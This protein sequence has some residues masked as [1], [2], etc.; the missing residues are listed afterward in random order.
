MKLLLAEDEFAMAD[1]VE[2]I[3]TY[4]NYIIDS[5][6]NGIDALH[7]ARSE[8]YDGIILDIM[9][10]GIGGF[11]VLKM[12]KSLEYAKNVPVVMITSSNA[13]EDQIKAFSLGANDFISKPFIE[14]SNF[15]CK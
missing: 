10:P 5:V 12:R 3:L 6:D 1:A 14:D 4:H 9:M 13:I 7:Y 11:G 8:H 2:D 15:T